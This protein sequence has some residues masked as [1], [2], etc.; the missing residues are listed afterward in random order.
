MLLAS[1]NEIRSYYTGVRRATFLLLGA[2]K[3]NHESRGE[4]LPVL[5]K[6][7]LDKFYERN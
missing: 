2:T 3:L 4:S 6:M 7:D 5:P 1:N